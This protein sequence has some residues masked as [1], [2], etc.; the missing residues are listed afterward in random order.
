METKTKCVFLIINH[1]IT[2]CQQVVL[3]ALDKLAHASVVSW[4]W[5]AALLIFPGLS[6]MFGIQLTLA[7]LTLA[8]ATEIPVCLSPSKRLAVLAHM[9]ARGEREKGSM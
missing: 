6:Q 7:M 8:K 9:K 5:A 4:G 2:S 1:N 3:L